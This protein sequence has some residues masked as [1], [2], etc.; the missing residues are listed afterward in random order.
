M[1]VQYSIRKATVEDI[2]DLIRLRRLMF[3]SMN[4][5]D[6]DILD[7]TDQSNEKYFLVAIPNEVFHGWVAEINS[8][9]VVGC[10]GLVFDSHPP[11]PINYSGKVGYI[12]NMSV[13]P[14]YRNQ[15]IAKEIFKHILIFLKEQ[16]IVTASLHATDM[17]RKLY[18]KFGFASTNEMRLNLTTIDVTTIKSI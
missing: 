5:K 17:G 16:N 14:D 18:E 15:G 8:G 4:Y 7:K 1:N 9:K 13:Y 11:G 10:G 3:E 6:L 2:T 12:M